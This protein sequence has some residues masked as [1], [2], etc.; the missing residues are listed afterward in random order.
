[1]I[2]EG[3]RKINGFIPQ[4]GEWG[5]FQENGFWVAARGRHVTSYV[6]VDI[7]E[8]PHRQYS[9]DRHNYFYIETEDY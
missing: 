1:M 3:L 9:K 5:V 4:T 2:I 7:E 6:R 8:Y